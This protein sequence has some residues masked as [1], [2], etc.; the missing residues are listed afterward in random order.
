M[1]RI[2]KT[3]ALVLVLICL[4]SPLLSTDIKAESSTSAPAIERQKTF[5]GYYKD[6]V[7]ESSNLIQTSDGG[8]AF[9]DLG[10]TYQS[11]LEPATV[12]KVNSKG[13]L[14]W[15]KTVTQFSGE[16]IIQTNDKGYEI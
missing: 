16:G 12:F 10:Y 15:S 14:Q 2:S 11:F 3:L 9:M 7:Q 4:F 8:Y 5:S 1:G 6:H 13:N